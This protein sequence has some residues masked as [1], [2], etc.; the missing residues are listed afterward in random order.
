MLLVLGWTG[1]IAAPFVAG[2]CGG[3]LACGVGPLVLGVVAPV[4]VALLKPLGP[5]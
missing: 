1:V 4:L 5:C 2:G 3:K